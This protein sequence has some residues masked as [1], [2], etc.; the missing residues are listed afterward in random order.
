MIKHYMT[1]C[2]VFLSVWAFAA[3]ESHTDDTIVYRIGVS[4]APP[5]VIMEGSD[6]SG[7]AVSLWKDVSDR[8][9]IRYRF[10]QY[11]EMDSMIR[12]L[13]AGRLDMVLTPRTISKNKEKAIPMTVPFHTSRVSAIVMKENQMPILKVLGNLFSRN[14]IQVFIFAL[15]CVFLFAMLMWIAERKKNPGMFHPSPRG[16]FDGIWWAVVTMA[17]V[18]YGETVPK[19]R[20]GRLIAMA[21]MFCA[22]AVIFLITSE[23]A[24]ELTIA[25]M[26]NRSL[27]VEELR[28]MRSVTIGNTGYSDALGV[29]GIPHIRVNK[30]S[31]ALAEVISGNSDAFIF[32]K[33][34]LA[35]VL[36]RVETERPLSLIPTGLNEQYLCFSAGHRMTGRLEE[37]NPAILETIQTYRWKEVLIFYNVPQ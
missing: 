25:K 20:M 27:E 19:T 35:Y 6:V 14:T 9:A 36:D 1:V 33:A 12:D 17:T 3:E 23:I 10:V 4:H 11:E 16:I 32:D 37:I 13:K 8:L 15:I 7:A 24:S 29:N 28:D 18:G 26:E 31:S 34:V 22:I 21:W 2:L 30:V 5:Y